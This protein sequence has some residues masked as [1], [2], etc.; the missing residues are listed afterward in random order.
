[1]M[2]LNLFKKA[3]LGMLLFT[4]LTA[5]LNAQTVNDALAAFNKGIE[6]S[7]T[8][9]FD[10]A[11]ASF[12]SAIDIFNQTEP[13][14]ETKAKAQEQIV[15]V[16]YKKASGLLKEKK[17]DDCIAAFDKLVE[18]STSFNNEKYLKRANSAIPKIHY[19]KGKDLYDTKQY[20]EALG[21][22]NKS[23]ELD[24]NYP[25][26]YVRK[27]QVFEDKND[28]ESFKQVIDLAIEVS[29]QSNDLKSEE[30]AK[31]IA[32]NFFLRSGA[33]AFKAE[34]Y[35][36]AATYFNSVL[37][38][39]EG[40]TDIYYQLAAIY[41]KLSKWDEAITAANKSLELFKEQGTTKDARIYFELGNAYVG[42]ADNA[43]ACDAYK[44]ANKG[45]YAA[46]SKYQIEQV[47][48]CQ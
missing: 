29:I 36:N 11:I 19:A 20:D 23:I 34:K 6:L 1:M 16:Q 33:D 5:T 22:L 24:P 28:A 30:T 13:E 9:K 40:D 8:D 43:A 31:Q 21:S 35:S 48:K 46:A 44:K 3:A 14:N 47:L 2:K 41:N 15:V 10:E 45:D 42:K 27:A 7:Q 37:E 38:Y 18:Y 39:K 4:G 26:A 32:G 17:Y 12:T 25:M